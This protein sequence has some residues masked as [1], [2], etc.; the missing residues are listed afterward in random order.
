MPVQNGT[1]VARSED[2]QALEYMKPLLIL[3]LHG[4][5]SA[6]CVPPIVR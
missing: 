3:T 1:D 4:L 5:P 2:N 6:P